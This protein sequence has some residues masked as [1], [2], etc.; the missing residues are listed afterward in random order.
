MEFISHRG[1]GTQRAVAGVVRLPLQ[2]SCASLVCFVKAYSS[3]KLGRSPFLRPLLRTTWFCGGGHY[4]KL[5]QSTLG[6]F[7]RCLPLENSQF[8]VQPSTKKPLTQHPNKGRITVDRHKNDNL[9]IKACKQS[10]KGSSS[11]EFNKPM[12]TDFINRQ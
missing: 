5:I 12:A 6:F 3:S 9:F 1:T 2:V 7:S 11:G 8:L 10:K 4:H